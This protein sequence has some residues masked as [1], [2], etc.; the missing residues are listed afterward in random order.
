MNASLVAK[1]P[2]S[3]FR[4][5]DSERKKRLLRYW[6]VERIVPPPPQSRAEHESFEIECREAPELEGVSLRQY[7]ISFDMQITFNC[8]QCKIS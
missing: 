2:R 4:A 1:L 3:W 7:Q 5:R 6:P 8:L